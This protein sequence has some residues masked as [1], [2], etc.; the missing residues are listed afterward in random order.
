MPERSAP[1]RVHASATLPISTAVDN[2][3]IIEEL[4]RTRRPATRTTP[5][6]APS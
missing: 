2:G 6:R 5:V 3:E 1:V 4:H